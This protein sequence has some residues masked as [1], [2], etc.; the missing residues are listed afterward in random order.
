MIRRL[1]KLS[2]NPASLALIVALNLIGSFALQIIIIRSVGLGAETD[3]YIAAQTL[4]AICTAVMCA[5]L[6]GVWLHRFSMDA[7]ELES[8]V[9]NT[10]ISQATLIGLGAALFFSLTSMLWFGVLFPG[11]ADEDQ[12]LISTLNLLNWGG[13]A[14]S[15]AFFPCL[16]VLRVRGRFVQSE[17]MLFIATVLSIVGTYL[18]LNHWGLVGAA[19]IFFM[20]A[21]CVGLAYFLLCGFKVSNLWPRHITISEGSADLLRLISGNSLYK[22]MPIADRFFGSMAAAGSITS[23]NLATS[24]TGALAALLDR[25]VCAPVIAPFGRFVR[26]ADYI[27]FKNAYRRVLIGL[28][29]F[30]S[31]GIIFVIGFFE[32]LS[33]WFATIFNSSQEAGE[34]TLKLTLLLMGSLYAAAS[35]TV[36]VAGFYALGDTKTPVLIGMIGFIIGIALKILLFPVYG[37]QGL[38]MA[39]STYL[40]FNIFLFLLILE[41]K[42]SRK[43]RNAS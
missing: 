10:A 25:A 18:A 4:P 13:T 35:G 36:L 3:L 20:K 23:Y 14:V 27:G 29:L 43:V 38:A 8:F 12:S 40:M 17:L 33:A 24:G 6:Q 37:M 31:L 15:V 22:T 9:Y 5:S 26:A 34:Q 39:S 1:I 2:L 19:A 41:R 32:P 7:Q 16:L 11:L 21:L 42:V 28:A 30:V